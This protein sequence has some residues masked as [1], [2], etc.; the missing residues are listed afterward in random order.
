MGYRLGANAAPAVGCV[1]Y[2]KAGVPITVLTT[3]C[4]TACLMLTGS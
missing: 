2:L 3:I 4:G 1:E